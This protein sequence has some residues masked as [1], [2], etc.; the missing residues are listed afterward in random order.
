[1]KQHDLVVIG[2]G[3]AGY[4]AALRAAQLGLDAACIEKESLLGGT[5]LRVGCIPSK[6]L[7]DSTERY[8]ETAHAL[9]SHGIKVGQLEIDLPTMMKRKDSIVSGLGRGVS[10]LLK[11]AGVAHYAGVGRLDGEGRV[12]VKTASD[13]E[14]LSARHILIATGSVAASLPGVVIDEDRV[15]SSTGALAFGEVPQHLVVIG[16][17][18]I[19]LELGSVWCRLG[20]KVTVVEY[21][22]RI[23]PGNDLE[24]AKEAQKILEKQGLS[25][26]LACAVKGVAVTAQGCE[27]DCGGDTLVAD[28]VLVAVGR[29]PNT[30]GLGHET[31][32]L[33]LDERGRI[34]VDDHF[35]TSVPGLYAVGDVI[36]G[37]MLAHKAEEEAVACV[38]R[39]VTGYGHVNYDAIPAIVYTHPEVASVGK[40]E[41]DLKQSG[42]AYRRGSF[43][44]VANGRARAMGE[45]QG[46][47]KVLADQKTDRILGVHIVGPRAGD[48]IA[49][50]AAAISFGASAED[51]ARTCHA[52][53]TL[54]ECLKEACLAVDGR[55]LHS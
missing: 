37:A 15:V 18:A 26:R 47:V 55:S 35:Q 52:H 44:F 4:V 6:A 27:V 17:G 7:L 51:L 31:V 2:G 42:Q 23:L 16:A 22:D 20:A 33:S 36:R 30:A 32:G 12:I 38:E 34:P 43:P 48:L 49:E 21:L 8:F 28:R 24:I 14:H 25:F 10:S 5:C 39:I 40:T 3:P 19:G 9:A 46:L 50:A 41:E 1:M 53:P 11:K 45:S 13:E 54:S 29:R